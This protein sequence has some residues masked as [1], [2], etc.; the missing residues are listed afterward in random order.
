MR[1]HTLKVV[2]KVTAVVTGVTRHHPLKVVAMVTA[3]VTAVVTGV[4]RVEPNRTRE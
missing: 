3:M 2:A 4:T 1:H